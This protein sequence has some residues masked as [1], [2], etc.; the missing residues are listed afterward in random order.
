MPRLAW[1]RGAGLPTCLNWRFRA[2]SFSSHW[3]AALLWDLWIS[4]RCFWWRNTY[5]ITYDVEESSLCQRC[6]PSDW[7]GSAPLP[8]QHLSACTRTGHWQCSGKNKE[9]CEGQPDWFKT[10]SFVILGRLW[11]PNLNGLKW[12]QCLVTGFPKTSSQT[13]QSMSWTYH[14]LFFRSC[15][16]L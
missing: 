4:C 14:P 16:L 7:G 5:I 11:V 1:S 10:Q 2:F 13:V 15:C 12:K 8:A 3:A 6:E 9:D